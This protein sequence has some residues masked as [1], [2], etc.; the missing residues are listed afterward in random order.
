MTSADAITCLY[1]TTS[2]TSTRFKA[3]VEVNDYG[4][5]ASITASGGKRIPPFATDLGWSKVAFRDFK[6]SNLLVH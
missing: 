5:E 4:M 3:T 6:I 2:P 1:V